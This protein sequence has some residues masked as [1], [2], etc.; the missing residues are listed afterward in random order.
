[1]NFL[2]R[3]GVLV[4]TSLGELAVV[5]AIL[6][7]SLSTSLRWDTWQRSVRWVLARQIYFTGVQ[8]SP[9]VG[10]ISLLLGASIV[11]QS[12]VWLLGV[13][14]SAWIGPFLVAVLLR[15]IAPLVVNVVMLL[16]SGS[17][18]VTELG[19]M[20]V[21][22]EVRVL[23]GQGV[24]PFHY[25]V[26]PR[27]IGMGISVLCLTVVFLLVAFTSGYVAS[28]VIGV[29]P[30]GPLAFTNSVLGAIEM[31]DLVI[32]GGKIMIPAM[33][34]GAI[35]CREGLSV[36]PIPTEVPKATMRALSRA[37]TTLFVSSLILSFLRYA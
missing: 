1:M 5:A 36:A 13:G 14:Q 22:G 26:V 33:L 29:Q 25:L 37:G 24:D 10:G 2:E 12:Q 6:W 7:T 11:L 23:E 16:R 4:R 18:V 27:V 28:V 8:A 17:A 15:E 32:L 30:A 3:L 20:T 21:S 31:R 35:C 34:T 19:S 9:I